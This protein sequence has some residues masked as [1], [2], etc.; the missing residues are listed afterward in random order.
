M[1]VARLKQ[2]APTK[3]CVSYLSL[4]VLPFSSSPS[5]NLF[6][7]DHL[8]ISY[9]LHHGSPFLPLNFQKSNRLSQPLVHI[10]AGSYLR[11]ST[12]CSRLTLG[13]WRMARSIQRVVACASDL[14]APEPDP[15]VP[16]AYK[17]VSLATEIQEGR[18][19][20]C[21]LWLSTCLMCYNGHLHLGQINYRH[22]IPWKTQMKV[23]KHRKDLWR[24]KWGG[25]MLEGVAAGWEMAGLLE[26]NW[27]I[28]A[29][30]EGDLKAP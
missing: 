6:Q 12:I 27:R 20:I 25:R 23:T 7:H 3:S 26:N 13:S 2:R 19:A 9:S 11:L 8:F 21:T 15:L 1:R 22:L 5:P 30:D 16:E 17:H 10:K 28:E 18:S 4:S 29:E 14:G 24:Q